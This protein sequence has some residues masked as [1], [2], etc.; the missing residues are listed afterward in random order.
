M[1][2]QHFAKKIAL[3]DVMVIVVRGWIWNTNSVLTLYLAIKTAFCF[4][5]AWLLTDISRQFRGNIS[6]CHQ[7][8]RTARRGDARSEAPEQPISAMF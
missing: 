1:L 2:F 7:K 3:R 6:C 8:E 5:K 4:T